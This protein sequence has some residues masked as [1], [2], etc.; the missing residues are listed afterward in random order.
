MNTKLTPK[1]LLD[2]LTITK[3]VDDE[4]V[5]SM[6]TER[7]G[8]KIELFNVGKYISNSELMKEYENRGLVPASPVDLIEAY[9]DSQP[10]K[11]IATVWDYNDSET[12]YIA[13]YRW[14]GDRRNVDVVRRGLGWRDYWW[15][16]GVRKSSELRSSELKNSVPESLSQSDIQHWR[17][18]IEEAIKG[19]ERVIENAQKEIDFA[20]K[21]LP[22]I[23]SMLK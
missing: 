21:I 6:P 13:F 4:V 1:Q 9:K 16:A 5:A 19:N 8:E 14:S 12:S 10:E 17:E 7:S 3:Y 22:V 23:K 11:F 20:R 2:S 18:K 15:F